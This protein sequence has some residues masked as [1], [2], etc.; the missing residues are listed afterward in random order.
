MRS[1]E[2][3]IAKIKDKKTAEMMVQMA[4]VFLSATNNKPDEE[5]K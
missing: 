4:N 3:S 2:N 1:L 5:G